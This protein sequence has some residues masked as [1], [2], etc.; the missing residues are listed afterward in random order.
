MGM[1]VK[2]ADVDATVVALIG[3]RGREVREFLEH[4]LG[5][6][7]RSGARHCLCYL[8][9]SLHGT[10]QGRVRGHGHRRIFP[11]PGQ[12]KGRRRP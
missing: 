9:Q 1:L 11:R 2:G 12:E 3:E 7:G 8:R 5:E 4:E 6:E 10:G